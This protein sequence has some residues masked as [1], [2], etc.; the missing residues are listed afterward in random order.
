MRCEAVL[1]HIAQTWQRLADQEEDD[2][3][4]DSLLWVSL[5]PLRMQPEEDVEE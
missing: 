3:V 1:V 2:L 4:P 5:R